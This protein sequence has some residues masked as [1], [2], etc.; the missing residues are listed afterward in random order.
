METISRKRTRGE[1]YV[2]IWLDPRKP[3]VYVYG[4]YVFDFE[5]IYVGKG[6]R[7]RAYLYKR[8]YN[9]ILKGKILKISKPIVK[10]ITRSV[11][12]K[13]AFLLEKKLV[14][15]IGR[16]IL[17]KGPLCNLSDGGEG[18]GGAIRSDQYK[19]HL[20]TIHLGKVLSKETRQ[21]ISLSRKGIPLTEEH[22]HNVS[23]AKKGVKKSRKTKRNMVA[24]WKLRREQS[25]SP[26][27]GKSS[28]LKGRP[29]P[30]KGIKH[31]KPSP[32]K[33][34]P[35]LAL[36]GVKKSRKTKRNMVAAWKL[37]REK[38]NS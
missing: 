1:Y 13:E 5:P 10:F 32:L 17:K 33:G 34:R 27:K 9:P 37:R 16:L 31:T 7:Q 28:P 26:L 20:S 14:L 23:K 6:R 38:E 11:L 22:K 35:N 15:L 2:Y 30:L 4:D 12:E 8:E 3:G 18:N 29:S 19:K 25:P 24:A 36:K 21:K